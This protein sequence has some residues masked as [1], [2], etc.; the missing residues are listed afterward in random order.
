VSKQM[1]DQGIRPLP[2]C[3]RCA[4]KVAVWHVKYANGLGRAAPAWLL[5]TGCAK[6][7]AGK[8]RAIKSSDY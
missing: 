2:K 3:Q 8:R 4:V 6:S 1:D 5:C 7:T